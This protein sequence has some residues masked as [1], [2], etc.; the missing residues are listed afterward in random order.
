[1]TIFYLNILLVISKLV[2]LQSFIIIVIFLIMIGVHYK[3][4]RKFIFLIYISYLGMFFMFFSI[5]KYGTDILT[6]LFFKKNL[7]PNSFV[8]FKGDIISKK[9]LEEKIIF[10][11]SLSKDIKKQIKKLD[12][13]IKSVEK[14]FEKIKGIDKNFI[15]FTDI[16]GIS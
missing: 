6:L 12:N 13:E 11:Y 3:K 16:E 7:T 10:S 8:Q 5:N 1:M 9:T 2:K 4:M 15:P 14:E